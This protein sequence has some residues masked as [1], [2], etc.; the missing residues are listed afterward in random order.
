M[1]RLSIRHLYREF[2]PISITIWRQTGDIGI[3]IADSRNKFKNIRVSHS[4]FTQKFSPAARNYLQIAELP[5]FGT[6]REPRGPSSL[7]YRLLCPAL[8]NRV[9]RLLHRTCEQR[10]CA[11]RCRFAE[12]PLRTA[13][14][15]SPIPLPRCSDRPL[16][17]RP[18]GLGPN[19]AKEWF[20]HVSL[21]HDRR[22]GTSRN[23]FLRALASAVGGR[24][25]GPVSC[26][27]R[28][29]AADA[30]YH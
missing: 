3:C 12:K 10:S 2:A 14:I 8:P 5:T 13:A 20:A 17:G 22:A 26:L 28:P 16:P 21:K 23:N 24:G 29:P 11:T 18:R 6:Q 7:R 19:P 15:V 4:I 25:G 1:P 27:D 30:I 9:L